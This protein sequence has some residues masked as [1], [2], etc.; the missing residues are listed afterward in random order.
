MAARKSEINGSSKSPRTELRNSSRLLRDHG[1]HD[2]LHQVLLP[3]L[4]VFRS[5]ERRVGKEGRS[6]WSSYFSSR[7]R[8]TRSKRDWV[9]TCALPIWTPTAPGSSG[10][11]T[12]AKWLQGKVRSMGVQKAQERN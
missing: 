11:S 2:L 7:R 4:G 1:L 3:V 9:Q 10:Y 6:R 5:E 8:H 12:R